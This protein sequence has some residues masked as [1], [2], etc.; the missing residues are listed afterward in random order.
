MIKA[1]A[2]I[3]MVVFVV[4]L[5]HSYAAKPV[6]K[7]GQRGCPTPTSTP[8]PTATPIPTPTPTPIPTATSTATPTATA[9][10]TPTPT[11]TSTTTPTATPTVTPTSVPTPTATPTAIKIAVI[12]TGIQWE[13]QQLL[14][15]ITLPGW[16]GARFVSAQDDHI[17][18][19]G[20]HVASAIFQTL[21]QYGGKGI[22]IVPFKVCD[23]KGEC[24]DTVRTA[25]EGLDTAIAA[26]YAAVEMPGVRVINAS[27]YSVVYSPPM[28]AAIDYAVSKGVVVV[29]IAGNTGMTLP[30]PDPDGIFPMAA[31]SNMIVVGGTTSSNTA[32]WP[33]STLSSYVDVMAPAQSV[34]TA[35]CHSPS[36]IGSTI[37]PC[38]VTWDGT[39]YQIAAGLPDGTPVYAGAAGTS[40]AAPQVAAVAAM[41]R[42]RSRAWCDCRDDV[43]YIEAVIKGAARPLV[44]DA[45]CGSGALDVPAALTKEITMSA[46]VSFLK[47]F[48]P[49]DGISTD[50]FGVSNAVSADGS[51]VAVG[52]YF[53]D[54]GAQT[55]AGAV[56]VYSGANWATET[57]LVAS[58]GVGTDHFGTGLW[59]SSDGSVIVT[60]ADRANVG[61]NDRGAVYVYSGANWA[62][63]TKLVASDG[64]DGDDLGLTVMMSADGSVIATGS[65]RAN[66]GGLDRGAVYVYSGVNWATETKIT[67]SDGAD[68]DLFGGY[69]AIS[70]D[71]ST[72]VTGAYA[73]NSARGQA[74][75]YYGTNWATEKI[76]TASDGESSD[77]FGS[78]V[79]V[80][81]DGAIVAIGAYLED[82]VGGTNRGAVYVY[83]G[84]NWGGEQKIVDAAPVDSD[85]FGAGIG[86]DPDG[87]FIAV[88]VPEATVGGK[89]AAGRIAVRWGAPSWASAIDLPRPDLFA[90]DKLGYD[91]IGVS[92]HY[93][94]AGVPQTNDPAKLPGA[95]YL[96][97]IDVVPDEI[98]QMSSAQ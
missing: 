61:G 89:A 38:P 18:G 52:V 80:S 31:K 4:S 10:T 83:S 86:I 70:A 54:V 69:V 85:F 65:P 46:T 79:A 45:G 8:V 24:A 59:M 13:H 73:K 2:S 58:D 71:G 63:E 57:K 29:S 88:A 64:A 5:T 55:D 37:G 53:A 15:Q 49:S 62:T 96:W 43:L 51:V 81:S 17:V 35:G 82:G 6:C 34:Y 12:D 28:Q 11:V 9:S 41:I 40:M 72:V 84:V 50:N 68:S 75:I 3:V 78:S 97:R 77:A 36:V 42:Q 14:G 32:I 1:I 21:Q 25:E 33:G 66:L 90:N 26:V 39:A 20:T 44:C 92:Q 23:Y 91:T 22:G 67:A 30:L 98:Y 74:Y 60:T 94:V 95:A 48:R 27:F 19:H 76:L 7:Q 87:K 16:H 93:V 56:Y 47:K